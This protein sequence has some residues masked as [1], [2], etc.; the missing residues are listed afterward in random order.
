MTLL[1]ALAAF[2]QI[3]LRKIDG[4]THLSEIV[5]TSMASAA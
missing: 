5:A 4:H 3:V 1:Y 2:G